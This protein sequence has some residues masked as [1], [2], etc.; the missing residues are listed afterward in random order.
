M[1]SK[2]FTISLLLFL[3]VLFLS[4]SDAMASSSR[5]SNRGRSS[6]QDTSKGRQSKKS[7]ELPKN[8]YERLGISP[9]ATDK[10]IKKAYRKLAV[11]VTSLHI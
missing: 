5:T 2:V 1:M 6:R 11:K 3:L 10:E 9:K 8:F 7:D 4:M